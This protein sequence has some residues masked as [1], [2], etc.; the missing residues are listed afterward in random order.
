MKYTVLV[1]LCVAL[2]FKAHKNQIWKLFF[3]ETLRFPGYHSVSFSARGVAEGDRRAT[4]SLLLIGTFILLMGYQLLSCPVLQSCVKIRR[5]REHLEERKIQ[6][7]GLVL[8]EGVGVT[9]GR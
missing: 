7:I 4:A 8:S 2:S 1:L 9:R 3:H 6:T 5:R